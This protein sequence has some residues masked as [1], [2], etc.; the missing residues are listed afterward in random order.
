MESNDEKVQVA[1]V[2][3]A[4][5]VDPKEPIV[6]EEEKPESTIVPPEEKEVAAEL[7]VITIQ[8]ASGE[9][10][11]LEAP[12]D[13]PPGRVTDEVSSIIG[14]FAEAAH[15]AG[16]RQSVAQDVLEGFVDAMSVLGA[17][18]RYE[19][20]D[21]DAESTLRG[22]WGEQY[23]GMMKIVRN[24]VRVLGTDFAGFLDETRLGS[25]PR[26]ILAIAN[27]T[28]YERSPESAQKEL[29]RLMKLPNYTSPDRQKRALIVSR[30]QALSRVANRET[31]STEG[32]LNAIARTQAAPVAAASPSASNATDASAE[33]TKM[34]SDRKGALMNSGHPDH[35]AAVKKYHALIAKL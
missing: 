1:P 35:D 17:D 34:M 9:R 3:A 13:V 19:G 8:K 16:L 15:I 10:Y 28:D 21:D 22:Y 14:A 2:A 27:L 31:A 23:D 33:A 32:R 11:S 4:P 6:V 12:A 7:E 18:N 30:I 25:D 26:A 24:N 20:D 29:D 5:V